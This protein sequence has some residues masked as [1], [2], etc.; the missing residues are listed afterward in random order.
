L[1]GLAE[2]PGRGAAARLAVLDLSALEDADLRAVRLGA[3]IMSHKA[4]LE[5]RPEVEGLFATLSVGAD[6]ELARR[7]PA[8]G[9]GNGWVVL[10]FPQHNDRPADVAED[11]RLL[12]ESLDLLRANPRLSMAVRA[13]YESIH[14]QLAEPG[15]ADPRSTSTE[16]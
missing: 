7:D 1:S 10:P 13:A 4:A 14:A 9:T 12:L 15:D 16:A 5:G 2:P 3:Q 11:R 6:G 8:G